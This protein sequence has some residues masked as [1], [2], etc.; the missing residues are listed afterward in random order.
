MSFDEAGQ[1]QIH[2][3]ATLWNDQLWLVYNKSPQ[4]SKFDVFIQARDCEGNLVYGPEQLDESSSNDTYPRLAGNDDHLLVVW[5]RDNSAAPHNL[6]IQ[7]R[8]FDGENW[9]EQDSWTPTVE[10]A[11]F[12]GNAWMPAIASTSSGAFVVAGAFGLSSS[13]FKTILGLFDPQASET[14]SIVSAGGSHTYPD[15]STDESG[16]VWAAWENWSADQ[17]TN[18][19]YAQWDE[20]LQSQSETMEIGEADSKAPSIAWDGSPQIL[21][22]QERNGSIQVYWN[23]SALGDTPINHTANLASGESLTHSIWMHNISGLN[24]ALM[25]APLQSDMQ[26]TSLRE[27]VAP[28]RPTITHLGQDRFFVGWIEGDSPDFY[29]YGMTT[30]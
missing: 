13:G 1:T 10:G 22:H 16:S 15:L 17:G 23:G 25:S 5:Q 30:P 2:P 24:N 29:F 20:D 27:K 7:H 14:T 21:Y 19:Q 28:Y 8:S 12:E 6:S 4:S 26:G 9:S 3:D 18:I 11:A